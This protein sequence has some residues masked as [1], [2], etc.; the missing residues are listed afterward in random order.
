MATAIRR[1]VEIVAKRPVVA[2]ERAFADQRTI[3]G[4]SSGAE[5][6]RSELR[7]TSAGWRRY[8]HQSELPRY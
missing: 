3:A 5:A 8:R 1:L 6:P 4:L 7:L 2:T